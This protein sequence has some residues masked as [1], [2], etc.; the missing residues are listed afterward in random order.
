[1][2]GGT[3]LTTVPVMMDSDKLPINRITISSKPMGLPPKGEKRTAHNAIEK[4]YRSSIND[5]ILE[6]KD[7]VAGTEAKLNKSAI[8]KKAI[9]YIRYLQQS[10]QK[11]KKENMALKMSAQKNKSL[12]DLVAMELDGPQTDVKSELPTPPP[13]DVGS[14]TSYSHCGSDSEPDSPMGEDSKVRFTT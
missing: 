12:K 6:L 10:N 8:L 14:P 7:L 3:F 13:S 4:R 11:L 9:D 2:S 1:M 5:K